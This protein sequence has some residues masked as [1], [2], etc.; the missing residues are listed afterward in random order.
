[1]NLEDYRLNAYSA[2]AGQN[3]KL[4]HKPVFENVNS[5]IDRIEKQNKEHAERQNI[6]QAKIAAKTG[7]WF[8]KKKSATSDDVKNAAK[9]LT[10]GGLVKIPASSTEKDSI[11]RRVAKFLVIVGIDEAAK[12]LPH[13]TEEQTEKI[14]PEIASI[15]K[16]TP[17]E[18]A[19][20]LEEFESLVEKAREEGGLET[21]RNILTKAYGSEKA[22][23]M[24]KKSVKYPDGKPFDYLSDANAERIKVLI[25]G[26][27]DAVKSLVLSQIEPKKAAK[28]INLMDVDD[29][30][31]IVLRLAKIKPVAPEVLAEIDR[32]LHE[33][34][35]TQNTENSQNMDG[36]GVLAQILKRMNPS[37]ENSIINT[38]SEQ[39]PELGEDLRKRLFTE[40]DVIGS[41]DRFIQNYLHD[42]EDR[43][44]AVLIYGKND[45]FRE[46]ILS[47]VSKNRRRVIL[48]EESMIHHLTKSDSEKMTSS[49]Y[50]VLRRA[51]ENGDLRVSGRDEGEV[52]V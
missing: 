45:A 10:S 37:V 8:E 19:S 1:M 22:E 18:S 40:E 21:A 39:D 50:S 47:N 38:L 13:L 20:I 24:L 3:K 32:S 34:L 9:N 35:L 2:G 4:V 15:Q 12:I 51:W 14:I 31:K 26:E 28:V 16:I 42:M 49:F 6:E 7:T 44:I 25:D 23:D 17:E 33:K 36:R 5:A 43:D 48:D 27:S 29:K 46:K 41:D 11:Y 52:Y 30:K